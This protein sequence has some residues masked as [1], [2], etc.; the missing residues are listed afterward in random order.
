M[1]KYPNSCQCLDNKIK[2]YLTNELVDIFLCRT[3]NFQVPDDVYGASS[4]FRIPSRDGDACSERTI[5]TKDNAFCFWW[6]HSDEKIYGRMVASAN[7]TQLVGLVD[8]DI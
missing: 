3:Q 1:I 7:H 8:G 4:D 6:Y 5:N 2:C